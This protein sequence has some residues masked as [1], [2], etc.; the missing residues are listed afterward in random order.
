M[1]FVV[2]NRHMR[3]D[4]ITIFPK[5][6]DSY[7][8]ESLFKRAQ[9][10]KILKIFAHNLRDF[11]LD[12]HRKVDDSPYGGGPGM[13]LKFEPIS[14]AVSSIKCPASGEARHGRQV[15][16]NPDAKW[17]GFRP[18]RWGE[19]KTRVILFST[20]GKKFNEKVAQRLAKYDQLIFICGR[21]E[22]VD[23]RVAKYIVDEEISIGDYIVSGGELPAMVVIDAVSRKL[24]GF[25]G[26]HESLEEVKGSYPVYTRPEAWTIKGKRLRVP[27]VLLN[28]NHKEIN[29][30]R[31]RAGG[32]RL[33]S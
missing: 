33:L 17:S 21:Y 23:E 7:F 5:I 29:A 22:G 27:G 26:K 16:G 30:W 9:K 18:K 1:P 8:N 31:R 32:K 4:I 24:K 19:K 10:N 20:R 2:L 15:S 14:K 28:G 13:V 3:F 12:K 6:F 25:L 11:T